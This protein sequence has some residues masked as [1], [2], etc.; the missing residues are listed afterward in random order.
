MFLGMGKNWLV[1]GKDGCSRKKPANISVLFR[2]IWRE[3]TMFP[4]NGADSVFVKISFKI[5]ENKLIIEEWSETA[6]S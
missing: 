4:Y 3:D 5:G 6:L 1:K 2:R